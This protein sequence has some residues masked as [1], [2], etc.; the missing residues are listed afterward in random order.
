MVYLDNAAT[1]RKKP[2]SVYF[3]YI[4]EV[5]NSAN[6]GRGGHKASMRAAEKIEETRSVI[7]R[8]F[9]DG[10]VV[11]TKNCTE[12]INLGLRVPLHGKKIITSSLEHNSVL[13]PLK[14]METEGKIKLVVVSPDENGDIEK[15]IEKKL[16]SDTGMVIFGAVSNV[17]GKRQNVE[18]I[19]SMVKK[20]TKAL[21]FLDCAQSA[22]V[23]EIDYENV[24]IIA[25][26]GHKALCGLQG[27]GFLLFRYPLRPE[28]L[29]YGGT[30]TSSTTVGIPNEMPESLEAGT[31][32]APAI[33]ALGK[34][35]ERSFTTMDR[36]RKKE[37][38]LSKLFCRVIKR[39][40]IKIYACS[41]GIV[42]CN[43]QGLDCR[44]AADILSGK[45]GVYVR[46]G[47]HCAPL[48]HDFLHTSPNGAIRVS[49]GRNN[50]Y[51]ST[52][53]AAYAFL[54]VSKK[55]STCA[56]DGHKM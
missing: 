34:G 3:C 47:L 41:N 9:F 35:I 32:N 22:G 46:S 18:R 1:S 17:T 19:A 51:C 12:A 31:Q 7:R 25:C 27:T 56:N 20:K 2:L 53:W 37:D 26:S 48:I 13:R 49:F 21:V 4:R 10:N 28:P 5:I 16:S 6:A 42:L 23:T 39:G 45:W 50:T 8:F 14:K 44:E 54:A 15:A 55:M 43:F 36:I 24:D 29:I 40:N 11:F 33:A 38:R 52:L 30:G